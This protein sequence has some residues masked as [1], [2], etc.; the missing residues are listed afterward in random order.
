MAITHNLEAKMVY[1]F[2]G[3]Y[4]IFKEMGVPYHIEN[5]I[6]I[7]DC[8]CKITNLIGDKS[9]LTFDVTTYKDKTCKY[10]VAVNKYNFSPILE[11]SD[12]FIKQAYLY[13]K[14]LPEYKDCKDC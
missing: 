11:S 8:Y 4:D 1:Y 2:G 9:A 5:T 12:N 14:T 10:V 6:T 13:L 7:N 3:E